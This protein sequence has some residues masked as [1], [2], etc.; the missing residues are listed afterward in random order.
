LLR[1]L[2]L[3]WVAIGIFAVAYAAAGLR[4]LPWVELIF[5]VAVGLSILWVRQDR[6][7]VRVVALTQAI[8]IFLVIAVNTLVLG[9]FVPSG[10][11]AIWSYLPPVAAMF[12]LEGR[13]RVGLITATG[14]FLVAELA[15]EP[16]L[17]AVES[18]PPAALPFF[19]FLNVSCTIIVVV[20]SLAYLHDRLRAENLALA[21]S[22]RRH[23]LI[24]EQV[25]VA[26]ALKMKTA[27]TS[28]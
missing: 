5:F 1:L 8:G 23:R 15:L 24:L 25:P 10:G 20:G 14:V 13:A 22:E 6:V 27:G 21:A 12:L 9:G 18:L 28:S 11:F 26:I 16:H 3:G 17:T 4:I 2:T 7:R 19:F